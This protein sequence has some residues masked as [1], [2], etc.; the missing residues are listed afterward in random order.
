MIDW[1][2][3]FFAFNSIS[4]TLSNELYDMSNDQEQRESDRVGE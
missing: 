2:G 4:T 1:L 3:F